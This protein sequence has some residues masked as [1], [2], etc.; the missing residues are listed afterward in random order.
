MKP[1]SSQLTTSRLNALFD[2]TN[3]TPYSL[4]QQLP[5]TPISSGKL[6]L[7][8]TPR[9]S[10]E[11]PPTVLRPSSTRKSLRVPRSS[12]KSFETPDA[13]GRRPNWDVSD[14]DISVEFGSAFTISDEPA[15]AE[16]DDDE[17]EYMA[18]S[19]PE[20]PYDPG[21]EMPDY[22]ALGAAIMMVSKCP[23]LM[24]EWNVDWA[25]PRED[26]VLL[27]LPPMLHV[28]PD[29]DELFV[30]KSLAPKPAF[31]NPPPSAGI[32]RARLPPSIPKIQVK[33]TTTAKLLPRPLMRSKAPV[34]PSGAKSA[35]PSKPKVV[36]AAS[37]VLPSQ[38]ESSMRSTISRPQ[39]TATR[40]H[41]RPVQQAPAQ[42]QNFLLGAAA[43]CDDILTEEFRFEL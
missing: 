4:R 28:P 23:T 10:L 36:P 19:V 12:S 24:N 41:S 3:K 21:F 34:V 2:K 38:P 35:I 27:D 1:S 17:I 11:E 25:G 5:V 13:R 14:G 8:V 31:K 26:L 39:G 33:P 42:N 37:R 18:P 29:E 7:G 43:S 32:N 30:K 6:Q 40:L 16:E 15:I 9:L 22:K 20:Q